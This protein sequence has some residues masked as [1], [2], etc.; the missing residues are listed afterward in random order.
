[1]K[2]SWK[3]SME[4]F[5]KCHGIYEKFHGIFEKFHGISIYKNSMEFLKNSMECSLLLGKTVCFYHFKW[6]DKMHT[7]L[8][9]DDFLKSC[10]KFKF[11]R[12]LG[13]RRYYIWT[14]PWWRYRNSFS[15]G[16]CNLRD[17]RISVAGAIWNERLIFQFLLDGRRECAFHCVTN[18]QKPRPNMLRYFLSQSHEEWL[19]TI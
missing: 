17:Q 14:V 10:K 19:G 4:F 13:Q 5:W 3:N 1:M 2:L 18:A 12:Q 7:F 16:V 11:L 9:V 15:Q 6:L 8:T